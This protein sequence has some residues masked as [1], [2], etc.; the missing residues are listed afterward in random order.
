LSTAPRT[1]VAAHPTGARAGP[2]LRQ[3]RAASQEKIHH[4]HREKALVRFAGC[5]LGGRRCEASQAAAALCLC[6]SCGG[7]PQLAMPR[8]PSGLVVSAGKHRSVQSPINPKQLSATFERAAWRRAVGTGGLVGETTPDVTPALPCHRSI[9]PRSR[10]L[11]GLV[12]PPGLPAAREAVGRGS[13]AECAM[14]PLHLSAAGASCVSRVGWWG[15]G[16]GVERAGSRAAGCAGRGGV[17]GVVAEGR[18]ICSGGH[19]D[20]LGG[21]AGG[22]VA[23]PVF[24]RRGRPGGGALEVAKPA[25]CVRTPHTCLATRKL[26]AGLEAPES[27]GRR[28]MAAGPLGRDPVA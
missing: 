9:R 3:R 25:L 21:E 11:R 18:R 17:A 14:N 28:L 4:R 24:G 20:G 13:F 1:A 15:G 19:A 23:R 12:I 2:R 26:P 8:P 10:R 22:G 27:L 6:A 16:V 7:S 5:P